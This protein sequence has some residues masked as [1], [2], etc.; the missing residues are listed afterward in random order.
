MAPH[1]REHP[2]EQSRLISNSFVKTMGLQFEDR[3]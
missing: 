2:S 3:G 1:V